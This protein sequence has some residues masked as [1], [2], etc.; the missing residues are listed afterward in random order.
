MYF[1][2]IC[3][4]A[5]AQVKLPQNKAI[6]SINQESFSYAETN[7]ERAMQLAYKAINMSETEHYPNG[8]AKAYNN[9]GIVYDV[10]GDYDSSLYYYNKGYE[11]ADASNSLKTKAGIINNIGMIYWNKGEFDIAL[12]KY[13]EAEKLY[14]QLKEEKGRAN[15][16]SNI[17]LIYYDIK[18]YKQSFDYCFAALQIREKIKDEYGMSVSYSNMASLYSEKRDYTQSISYLE[19]S[20]AIK[21]KIEDDYGLA[22]D[23]TNLATEQFKKTK[24]YETALDLNLEAVKIRQKIDD[25]FGLCTS[26]INISHIYIDEK[27]FANALEYLNAAEKLAIEIDAKSRLK[28]V[29]D[30]KSIL[31]KLTGRYDSALF[32]ADKREVLKDSIFTEESNKQYAKLHVQYET[33]KKENEIVQQK[34]IIGKRNTL[35][36]LVTAILFFSIVLYYVLYRN[37][38]IKQEKKLQQQRLEEQ[39]KRAQAII[40]TEENERQRLAREL[41]DGVGQL[42]SATRMNLASVTQ[43]NAT[44]QINKSIAVLDD[45]IQEIR[46]ISHNMVPDILQKMGLEKAVESFV[47]KIKSNQT[48]LVFENA[49]YE[50]NMLDDTSKLMLYRIIQECVNNA[51][52]Y[53]D[54]SKISILLTADERELTLMVEDNGKGFD[55][56]SLS[57]KSGIGMKNMELRTAFLHG[58]LNIDSSPN[59]GTTVIVDMPLG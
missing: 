24:N 47:H 45:S 36:A 8:I 40:E 52:K 15:T 25:K 5:V 14:A 50:E 33:E 53:A 34:L 44:Q 30:A 51:V 7:A 39:E 58:K 38:Q 6:D 4:S 2:S 3:I 13:F 18:Q 1:S 31:F 16:L 56:N 29:Y 19:K 59:N 9:I 49:G 28:E 32:Y 41:H 20:I 55:K 42:L 54:A 17:G 26:Y 43:E 21:K 22:I 37:Y 10:K 11:I 27:K 35:L 23:Y 48:E 57:E 12:K 46:H